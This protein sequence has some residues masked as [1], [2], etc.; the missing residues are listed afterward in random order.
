M[1]RNSDGAVVGVASFVATDG[2]GGCARGFP[3]GYTE[4][5]HF[6]NWLEDAS[7]KP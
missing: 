6:V 5:S 4:V 7:L 1:T 3:D 2:V